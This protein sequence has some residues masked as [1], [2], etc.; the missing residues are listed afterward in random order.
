MPDPSRP[1]IN[2]NTEVFKQLD[3]LSA[4]QQNVISSTFDTLFVAYPILK[5][6]DINGKKNLLSGLK[7]IK[8][9]LWIPYVRELLEQQT[10]TIQW[11][12]YKI[13]ENN[14]QNLIWDLAS[15]CEEKKTNQQ[16]TLQLTTLQQHLIIQQ[17]V[18][19]WKQLQSEIQESISQTKSTFDIISG[20][21]FEDKIQHQIKSPETVQSFCNRIDAV[22]EKYINNFNSSLEALDPKVVKNMATGMSFYMMK[23]LN[24]QNTW[25]QSD[26]WES[27]KKRDN[28][29][30]KQ[31]SLTSLQSFFTKTFGILNTAWGSLTIF[32]K[33]ASLQKVLTHAHM[34][35]TSSTQSLLGNPRQFI[36]LME[37]IPTEISETQLIQRYQL[38]NP[39]LQSPN[40]PKSLYHSL[41][42]E[43][44]QKLQKIT[45]NIT[46]D[47]DTY[48]WLLKFE[49]IASDF[50]TQQPQ[51][52]SL[53]VDGIET[54]LWEQGMINQ[55]IQPLKQFGID[56]S[57]DMERLASN[58]VKSST[59]WQ[60]LHVVFFLLGY[61]DGIDGFLS[62][63]YIK[64]MKLTPAQQ[65]IIWSIYDTYHDTIQ[66]KEHQSQVSPLQ[67]LWKDIF[68]K[69]STT[70]DWS[71]LSKITQP[72]DQTDVLT[73]RSSDP[74]INTSYIDHISNLRFDYLIDNISTKI[75][76]W[77][78]SENKNIADFPINL[79]HIYAILSR[80][81]NLTHIRDEIFDIQELKDNQGNITI[82]YNLKQEGVA[83]LQTLFDNTN[84]TDNDVF[85]GLYAREMLDQLYKYEQNASD[86]NKLMQTHDAQWKEL[87]S[88]TFDS[89]KMV[90][91]ASTY[92]V[93]GPIWVKAIKQWVWKIQN[94][95]SQT[96]PSSP[97]TPEW[98]E[99]PQATTS[100]TNWSQTQH[101]PQM[102]SNQYNAQEETSTSSKPTSSVV[103]ATLVPQKTIVQEES[104]WSEEEHSWSNV[105]ERTTTPNTLDSST[106]MSF[107]ELLN[108]SWWV[109]YQKYQNSIQ[110][111]SKSTWVPT[112][113]LLQLMIKEGSK[114]NP[115]SKAWWLQTTNI[116][117]KWCVWLGQ[118]GKAAWTDM[119]DNYEWEPSLSQR[120][121]PNA[122]IL[123]AAR[124]LKYMKDT[125]N[126]QNRFRAIA[127]YNSG[128]YVKDSL[129]PK[130]K[131]NNPAIAQYM[132][133][134]DNTVEWYLQAAEKYYSTIA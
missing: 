33:L 19:D 63:Y 124:Y 12:T 78:T 45:N 89:K 1:L 46:F 22:W 115:H 75:K 52:K 6:M 40:S 38:V 70:Q 103:V 8:D 41:T 104:S 54:I 72:D 85:I 16:S 50:V 57:V 4:L 26:F 44:T 51:Y 43:E 74:T 29:N 59:L 24:T 76:E 121:D 36:Q 66:K 31:S 127:Y 118:M 116:N 96:S 131:K 65:E 18:N 60:I 61:A 107:S 86:N 128:L 81:N 5:Q 55:I 100:P 117:E 102:P 13:Q 28:S 80:D 27:I 17:S 132:N 129:I 112:N 25:Q 47:A 87:T 93:K 9:T 95:Q 7:N 88:P 109:P 39:S 134:N 49:H 101:T 30:D 84:N 119:M 99:T 56:Y 114:W 106:F 2:Q 32:Q 73:T 105:P 92:I 110:D 98:E 77:D 62:E 130:W 120:F 125:K 97:K 69:E 123:Q 126:T 42:K 68:L 14:I 122:Q 20:T 83:K 94:V 64:K 48:Q 111:A 34:T 90:F 21:S 37:K 79:P 35:P 53:A 23:R 82:N 71:L 91:L 58:E 3:S 133:K 113:I 67:T 10:I 11:Q 15:R 108:T